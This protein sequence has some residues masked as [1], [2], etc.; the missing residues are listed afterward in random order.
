MCLPS[1]YLTSPH[2]KLSHAGLHLQSNMQSNTRDSEGMRLHLRI[3][4][5]M[6]I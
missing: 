6:L 4:V 1:F 2:L 3:R 5:N